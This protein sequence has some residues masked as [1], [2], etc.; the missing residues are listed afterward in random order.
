MTG[1]IASP[2]EFVMT[3]TRFLLLQTCNNPLRADQ[4]SCSGRITHHDPRGSHIM[5]RGDHTS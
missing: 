4:A 2:F 3:E 5:I 1:R